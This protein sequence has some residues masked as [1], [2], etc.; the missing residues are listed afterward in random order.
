MTGTA[1]HRTA[2][3]ARPWQSMELRH[4]GNVGDVMNRKSGQRRDPSFLRRA[5]KRRRG[6]VPS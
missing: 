1:Q 5:R 4:V 2:Q 3:S 6:Q